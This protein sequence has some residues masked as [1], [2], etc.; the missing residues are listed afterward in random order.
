[1][2]RLT[3]YLECGSS[4][5]FKQDHP[6]NPKLLF[7]VSNERFDV[8]K[9]QGSQGCICFSGD[10]FISNFGQWV[11]IFNFQE[12][13]SRFHIEKI[14]SGGAVQ[15]CMPD[16]TTYYRYE[17]KPLGYEYRVYEPISVNEFA[18]GVAEHWNHLDGKLEKV[19]MDEVVKRE[20]VNW[21]NRE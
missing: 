20:K 14:S 16:S 3:P 18:V 4:P 11:Y 6:Y 17:S 8:L 1:M 7:H 9:P 12:L 5:V 21:S 13:N 15:L 2:N 10:T 19:L